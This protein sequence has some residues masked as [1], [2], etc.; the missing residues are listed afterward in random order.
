MLKAYDAFY[1]FFY[2]GGN[3]SADTVRI[4]NEE[5]DKADYE[6]RA[7]HVPKT[8]DNDLV[9][10]DHTPGYGSAA[11]FVASAFTGVN[12]DNPCLTWSIYRCGNGKKCRISYCRFCFSTKVSR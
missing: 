12:L 8:I 11:R 7:I 9:L 5:A 6:F 1:C 4:V 2:I 10:S 3:D